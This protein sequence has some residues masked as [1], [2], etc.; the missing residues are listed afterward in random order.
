MKTPTPKQLPSGSWRIQLTVGDR[1]ISITDPDRD[2]CVAKAMAYSAGILKAKKNPAPITLTK[3]IDNYI[4]ARA[5]SLSPSTVRGY[6]AIQKHRFTDLMSRPVASITAA[7]AQKAVNKEVP[8]CNAKTLTNA[9]RFVSSVIYEASGE[10]L[11]IALPPIIPNEHPYLTPEQIPIFLE[12]IKNHPVEIPA[13]LGLMSLRRSEIAGLKWS[14]VDLENKLI[15]VEG[16]SVVGENEKFV[17]KPTNKNS[18][19]RRVVPITA[20]LLELLQTADR[21]GEYVVTCNPHSI[22]RWVNQICEANGLPLIGT[23]GL[24]H[25]FA[26]LAYY[27]DIPEK[28][29]MKIGGWAN[30]ATMRKIYTHISQN[31]IGE[32]SAKLLSFFDNL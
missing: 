16:A 3:A 5:H 13:L 17:N 32:E 18:T 8:L 7:T 12:A 9:W 28:T 15:R 26:S 11:D 22:R 14:S 27:L 1:R 29:A 2:K 21:K 30:D 23:H 19:S 10:R 4:E 31:Q 25:S 24:R 20:R 6:R